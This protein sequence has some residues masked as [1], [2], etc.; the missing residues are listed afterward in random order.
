MTAG[1]TSFCPSRFSAAERSLAGAL[2]ARLVSCCGVGCDGG[3]HSNDPPFR[4]SSMKF[5]DCSGVSWSTPDGGCQVLWMALDMSLQYG[6]TVRGA[7]V[8]SDSWNSAT[9]LGR[10]QL[11]DRRLVVAGRA[12]RHVLRQLGVEGLVL[13]AGEALERLDAPP[14]RLSDV[15]LT[16][17]PMPPYGGRD[18]SPSTVWG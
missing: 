5:L 2:A 18:S 14:P 15:E 10:E 12:G 3:A 6:D 11:L 7:A 13:G 1:A 4:M 8:S 9:Q 17:M 16:P